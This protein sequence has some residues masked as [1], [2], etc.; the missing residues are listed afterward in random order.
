MRAL[1]LIV[2]AGCGQPNGSTAQNSANDVCSSYVSC[3]YAAAPD[4]A[5]GATAA[6]GSD[7]ACWKTE[8][9]DV[10]LEGCSSGLQALHKLNPSACPL[11]ASD[12]DCS[13]GTPACDPYGGECV[14]CTSNDY[15]SGI[16]CDPVSER[17]VQ[18]AADSDCSG[19]LPACDTSQ[20]VCVACTLDSQCRSG[21]CEDDHTC[22]VPK[23]SGC[24]QNACDSHDDG[25]GNLV[26]CGSCAVG[27]CSGGACTTEGAACT[28]GANQC[29]SGQRCM[30]DGISK[31]YLCHDPGDLQFFSANNACVVI[32]DPYC[33]GPNLS[34]TDP[35]YYVCYYDAAEPCV[36]MC[37][38]AA[39]CINGGPCSPFFD[40][41]IISAQKPGYCHS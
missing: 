18:C 35:H 28:P 15:C 9:H 5:A 34:Y 37:L 19:K 12:A 24:Y 31:S 16:V 39:D 22:C 27:T 38:T 17:C 32:S 4:Q 21:R 7:G 10:C 3:V 36:Q 2:L 8:S 6:Y 14:A 23:W 1:L 20:Q 25:C 13:G 29:V 40:K 26:D 33:E 30:F 41:T 11:C